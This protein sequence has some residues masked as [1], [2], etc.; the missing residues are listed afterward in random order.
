MQIIK[1]NLKERAYNII[2][3][4]G[5]ISSL[6]KYAAK[7]GIGDSAF[8]ISNRL[9]NARHG[10][11]LA[12]SLRSRGFDVRFREVSDT[13]RSKSM[14]T[15]SLI[16]RDLANYDK[17][18]RVFIVAFG[19][20]VIGDLAG[21]VA[22]IYRRG[23]PYIQVPTT[24]LAQVDSAI[25]GKTAVDLPQGKN[26]VGAFYQPKLVFSDTRLLK[27]LDPR[28][29]RSGLAEV[30]KYGLIKDPGLFHYLE[31]KS[32]DVLALKDGALETIVFRS[33][34]IK[35]KIVEL[36]EFERKGIRTLLNF[37]HTIGHAIEAAGTFKRYNHGE[38]IALGMLVAGDIS[39][40]LGLI[41]EKT[42]EEIEDT[43]GAVGLP[44]A[45]RGLKANKIIE[46]H[47]HDKKFI[48]PRNRFVLIRGIGRAAIAED[49]PLGVIKEALLK[50]TA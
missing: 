32:A 23:I 2:V 41:K 42:V 31:D 6:G 18:R 47:F 10:L 26:L 43:V 21:F 7:L 17:G 28:Q 4:S 22:C 34:R 13:E 11:A 37:G 14:G 15:A 8:I 20:G 45:I 25:G 27:T 50:I 9:I 38:A 30:I 29:V 24:L 1:L 48:G 19:G 39:L 5:I 44:L 33:S 35:A 12:N 36:D 49:I 3:G 40:R 46:A 16:I